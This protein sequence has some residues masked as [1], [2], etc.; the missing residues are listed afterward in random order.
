MLL[1]DQKRGALMLKRESPLLRWDQVV[2]QLGLGP[3]QMTDQVPSFMTDV[4]ALVERIMLRRKADGT[5]GN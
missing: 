1:P 2:K 3:E 4:E 5:H